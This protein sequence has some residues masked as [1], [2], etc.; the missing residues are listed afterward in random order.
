MT[1]SIDS[2]I[3]SQYIDNE[4]QQKEYHGKRL[5]TML[6]SGPVV[7]TVYFLAVWVLSEFGC[8]S[9]LQRVGLFGWSAVALGIVVLTAIAALIIVTMGILSVVRWREFRTGTELQR[10]FPRFMTFVG[11]WLNGIFAVVVILTGVSMYI[12]EFCRW[13]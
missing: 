13:I 11:A 6:L 3:Q 7:Y 4:A 8:L 5:W 2:E 12:G 9:G 10:G 1:T